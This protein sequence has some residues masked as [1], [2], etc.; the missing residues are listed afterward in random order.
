VSFNTRI[1][2]FYQN[3][4]YSNFKMPTSLYA[5]RD[6]GSGWGDGGLQ[7]PTAVC[8]IEKEEGR[9]EKREKMEGEGKEGA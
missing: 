1:H 8:S 2:R 3:F 4:V 7:P 5:T 9:R 6:G